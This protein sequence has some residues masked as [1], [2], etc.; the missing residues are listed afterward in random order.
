MPG[1]VKFLILLVV[2]AVISLF[3]RKIF[4]TDINSHQ[5]SDGTMESYLLL[6]FL[7]FLFLVLIVIFV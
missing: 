1:V 2:F 4:V 6:I 3:V 5:W 7:L